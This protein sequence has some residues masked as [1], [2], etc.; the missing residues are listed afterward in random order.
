MFS[1]N[2]SE[3]KIPNFLNRTV[4]PVTLRL[5][6]Q[7]GC[8]TVELQETLGSNKDKRNCYFGAITRSYFGI[9]R[10]PLAILQ[11]HLVL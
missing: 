9:I 4:E 6:F 2:D 10:R 11:I 1:A 8:Y 3:K 7:S 5:L